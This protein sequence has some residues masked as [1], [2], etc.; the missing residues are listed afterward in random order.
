MSAAALLVRLYSAIPMWPWRGSRPPEAAPV[1][2]AQHRIYVLPT[3][4]G[5][6]FAGAMLVMLIASINY[7]LNLGYAF[8]FLLTGTAIASLIHA[9]HNLLRLSIRYGRVEHAFCGNSVTFHLFIDNP[10]PRRRPALK[11][12]AEQAA[13]QSATRFD[14]PPAASSEITL[15]LPTRRRGLLPL[16]RTVIET[17]WP[18]G[19]I[20]AWSVIMPGM[21]AF[22][23]PTPEANPPPL[24]SGR[25]K[26]SAT[27]GAS[28][29]GNED[30][31]GLR[32]YQNTD[33]P[34]HLAWKA[35]AR[36]SELMTKQFSTSEGG[37]LFFD[38]HA[39][40]D[41]LGEEA[42]LSRLTAWLLRAEQTG[43]RY[44][45]RLP[46]FEATSSRG[47]A[48][49]HRCLGALALHGTERDQDREREKA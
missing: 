32:N 37:D 43:Q 45:L 29:R 23:F 6:S 14:L 48:H 1:K 34:R 33:S 38:W 15:S 47:E 44:A 10:A 28:R 9:F 19:L 35:F 4:P 25:G 7:G 11:M 18:L 16:G 2:L 36:G 24:P 39:L 46:A 12:F 21:Q 17:R 8:T 20:R 5:L 49:L 40:P 22:V 42:R 13:A 26:R 41:A 30:F 31:A 27:W 3:R